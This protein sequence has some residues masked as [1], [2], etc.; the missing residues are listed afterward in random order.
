MLTRGRRAA[1]RRS[2]AR[3]ARPRRRGRRS[4]RSTTAG[5]LPTSSRTSTSRRCRRLAD[6][7]GVTLML[8]PAEAVGAMGTL[9]ALGGALR[10]GG[11]AAATDGAD[12]AAVSGT[13]G[14]RLLG[15][16]RARA[17]GARDG[18]ASRS[19][20]STSAIG[21]LC[22]AVVAAFDGAL[23]LQLVVFAVVSAGTLCL[24]RPALRSRFVN[25]PLDPVERAGAG[26]AARGRRRRDP[27]RDRA[28]AVRCASGPRTG[29]RARRTSSA[30]DVGA[31]VEV[32]AVE[33]VAVIVRVT[34]AE[35]A[36]T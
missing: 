29:A 6:G 27:G 17:R 26:R 2:C 12:R 25:A 13:T 3:R 22:A 32:V 16:P 18:H 20:G 19:S 31:T 9:A 4:R 35:A 15:R 36:Q 21:A 7:Q 14:G 30:I 5:R 23:W 11:D 8:V 33:G 1:S 34:D 24:T 28:D 10:A